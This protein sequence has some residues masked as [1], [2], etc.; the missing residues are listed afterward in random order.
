[1]PSIPVEGWT[2]STEKQRKVRDEW[3]AEAKY[4]DP[5][6]AK[7]H[8]LDRDN[9]HVTGNAWFSQHEVWRNWGKGLDDDWAADPPIIFDR[10]HETTEFF[11]R[12]GKAL[13]PGLYL[14]RDARPSFA[15]T[16]ADHEAAQAAQG[17]RGPKDIEA[18]QEEVFKILAN[19]RDSVSG[20]P[21]P[22]ANRVLTQL[23]DH[24]DVDMS[25]AASRKGLK[26][27]ESRFTLQGATIYLASSI[28]GRMAL[29]SRRS[30]DF[31][32]EMPV[33][34]RRLPY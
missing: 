25:V 9:D 21:G 8:G 2:P 3:L 30:G 16:E 4:Y 15:D 32:P 22:E 31:R 12:D 23:T 20:L 33:R 5:E 6:W 17:M 26:R 13:R 18:K 27:G 14:D 24:I 34:C 11:E 7:E 19:L 28:A 29:T 1:M 10:L